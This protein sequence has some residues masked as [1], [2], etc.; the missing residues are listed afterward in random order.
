MK[1]FQW[2]LRKP[3]L[4]HYS[5]LSKWIEMG[6]SQTNTI[7]IQIIWE[8]YEQFLL[9]QISLVC[10]N[11]FWSSDHF[12]WRIKILLT[13][14]I[15]NQIHKNAPLCI[16]RWRINWPHIFVWQKCYE[17]LWFSKF[18]N[19]FQSNFWVCLSEL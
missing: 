17:N 1:C 8:R 7:N 2:Y 6:W 16:M 12:Q 11:I 18:S 5:R 10:L 3:Y 9:R 13:K 15:F 19:S 14:I 4:V